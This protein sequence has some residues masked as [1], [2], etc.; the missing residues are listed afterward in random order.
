M[1]DE[2]EKRIYS[3]EVFYNSKK[4]EYMI[5]VYKTMRIFYIHKTKNDITK[6]YVYIKMIFMEKQGMVEMKFK[7]K[8]AN[9][10][11]NL[12]KRKINYFEQKVLDSL[13]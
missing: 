13:S 8:P 1:M 11:L 2:C 10:L 5:N 3:I 7:I 12:M 9:Q 6:Y 4:S